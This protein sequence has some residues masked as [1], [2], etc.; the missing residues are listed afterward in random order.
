M[1][2]DWLTELKSKLDWSTFAGRSH[3]ILL[4]TKGW[5]P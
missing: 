5:E 2:A 4:G 3:G 1:K